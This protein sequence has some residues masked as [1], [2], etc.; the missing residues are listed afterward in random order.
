MCVMPTGWIYIMTNR[1]NGTLYVRVT[2]DLTRRVGEHQMRTGSMFTTR[3]ELD[4]LV[5]AESHGDMLT[6]IQREKNMKHWPRAWKVRLI[7]SSNPDWEDLSV[8]LI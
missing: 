8:G 4:R 6:A 7:V 1:P 5:Y 3:Y 2:N